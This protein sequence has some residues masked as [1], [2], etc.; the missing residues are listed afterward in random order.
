MNLIGGLV[1]T[2]SELR[3]QQLFW[4]NLF[5]VKQSLSVKL[6]QSILPS[7]SHHCDS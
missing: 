3:Y 2:W 5:C 6:K 4:W 1:A 7:Q